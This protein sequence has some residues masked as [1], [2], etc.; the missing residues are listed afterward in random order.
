MPT[1]A[2]PTTLQASN[3]V[4]A[5][6]LSWSATGSPDSYT[7]LRQLGVGGATVTIGS[8]NTTSF[9]DADVGNGEVYYYSV[10]SNRSGY[11]SSPAS[12]ALSVTYIGAPN[13]YRP[14]EDGVS[15]ARGALSVYNGV[16]KAGSG[17]FA[18]LQRLRGL[19]NTYLR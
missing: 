3:I 16:V 6:R 5:V 4:G 17:E 2:A 15:D 18:R 11:T 12:A 13:R 8:S 19:T 1:L 9:N 14:T 10:I 7:I